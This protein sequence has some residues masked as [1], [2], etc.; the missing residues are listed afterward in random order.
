[1]IKW[2]IVK[3]VTSDCIGEIIKANQINMAAGKI[4]MSSA[5]KLNEKKIW[6]NK[7]LENEW[8][9]KRNMVLRWLYN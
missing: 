8:L 2:Q 5:K 6:L 9:I 4:V 1:M 3:Y 7:F